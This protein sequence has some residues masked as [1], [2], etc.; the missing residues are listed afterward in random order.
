MR[1]LGPTFRDPANFGAM[2]SAMSPRSLTP[3]LLLGLAVAAR[4]EDPAIAKLRKAIEETRR[5]EGVVGMSVAVVKDGKVVLCEGFGKRDAARRLPATADTVYEIGSST[6]SF[7][8]LLVAEAAQEG[9]LSLGDRPA[10]YLPAF[11][12]KDPDANARITIEDLLSHRSGLPRTDLAWYA[13]DFSRDEILGL[14]AESEPTAPLGKAWQYQNPMFLFAGMI[15]ERAYGEPY[16][17]LLREKIFS[18]LGMLHSDATDAETRAQGERA[19]GYAGRGLRSAEYPLALRPIDRI[20]PAGAIA[21]TARDMASYLRMLLADGA[22]E[23]RAVFSKAA[24]E[25]TRKPRIAMAPGGA[26]SYGLG[27]MLGEEHGAKSVFHGGNIDG[28]TA[29]VSLVP[30][31]GIGVVALSNGNAAAAPQAVAKLV[32]DALLAPVATTPAATFESAV[33]SE[34]GAYH[35]PKTPVE[36]AFSR[37]GKGIVMTQNGQRIPLELVGPKRYTIAKALF[38]TFGVPGP[39]GKPAVRLEQGGGTF[40]LVRPEPYRAPM[41][42]EAL[43]AKVVEAEGGAEAI[44]RHPRMVIHFHARMPSDAVDVYGVRYR[45]DATSVAEYGL[46]YGLNRRFAE[47]TSAVADGVARTATSFSPAETKTGQDAEDAVVAA[48]A[49][50]DLTPRRFYRKLEV[51]RED[52]VGG[53]KAYVLRKTLFG[54]GTIEEAV[55]QKDF[56]VLRRSSGRGAGRIQEDF[57]DFRNVDGLVVPFRAVATTLVGTRTVEDVLSVRFDEP[58]P[59]WPFRGRP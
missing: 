12:L 30:E 29:F 54:G 34:M 49:E 11:R 37:E 40:L 28:F 36:V 51:V 9:K 27:W 20:A 44:R 52:A 2:L 14:V 5:A 39:D 47:T 6:K 42:A 48:N 19:T 1:V 26:E 13:G 38:M 22:F 43:L 58:I 4:A 33:E 17:T 57:S 46:F 24:V 59:T 35:L 56:R 21:S 25:E 23:E 45:R 7:T 50:A 55:S 15:A 18:P 3:L 31:R 53:E 10:K 32:Y 41:D 8:A 16:A